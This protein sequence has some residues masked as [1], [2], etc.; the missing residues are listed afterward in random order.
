MLRP[1]WHRATIQ[2]TKEAEGR[3]VSSSRPAQAI[4][5]RPYPKIQVG[6]VGIQIQDKGL[7]CIFNIS[8][9]TWLPGSPS[10]PQSLPVT[11]PGWH[12]SHSA[13]NFPAQGPGFLLQKGSSLLPFSPFL[14]S[15]PLPLPLSL[16]LSLSPF[17][18]PRCFFNLFSLCSHAFSLFL[19]FGVYF[20]I[21]DHH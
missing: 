5:V 11:G 2:A 18:P 1:G 8:K 10:I 9:W 3:R 7:W 4:L 19:L 20:H 15:L 12:T 14:P 6:G 16:S 13:L 17:L 21:P